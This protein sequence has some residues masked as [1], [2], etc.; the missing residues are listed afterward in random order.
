MILAFC[1]INLTIYS[2]E[3]KQ[4]SSEEIPVKVKDTTI[5]PLKDS[6]NLKLSDSLL[7][8][9]KDTIKK[10]VEL[11]EG[12]IEHSADS[13]IR[14]DIINNKI[15][16]YNN[17]HIHYKDI[18]LTAGYIEIDNNTNSVIAKG[19][20]DSVGTYSQLPVFKQGNQES[21]QDT[22]QFNFKSEKAKIWNLKTEQQGIIILGE[23]SKKHNDSIIFIENIRLTTSDKEKPDYYIKIPKAK[24]IKDKKLVAGSSQLV[25]AD[26]PTPIVLPF[27]YIPLTKGRTSG[28]LMPTWGENNRQGYFLQNGGYYFVLNDNFDL[29]VLGDIYTNGS[30]GLRTESGYA[31]RYKFS[32]NFNFR[33]ENLINSLKG[34]DD[35]S[36][37]T[38]YNIRWSHSQDAKA[39]PNSRFSASVNLGSSQ[40]Y[41]QSNNEYNTNAFLNNNLSSS[42]SYYKNFV[43]TPFNVSLSMTHSQNTN[44]EEIN[45][46]LPSLQLNMDRIYPFTGKNGVKKNAIQ[47]TGLTYTMKGDNR[48]VTNDEFFFKKEMFDEAKSGIQHNATMNTNMKALKYFTISPSLNY[49]EVWYFDRLS[50]KFDDIQNAVVTDTIS[51]FS[52]F[53]EYST[54]VSLGTTFYGMF[55]FKK[56]NI[57]AIRHVVRPSVSYSYRP[58]FSS[59]NEE[60]Q[61]SDDPNDIGEYS[62]FAN[63][64]F[65]KPGTG[66]SNSLNFTLNNNLEAKLRKKDSTDTETE[67]KKII[68]LNNLNFSSSYN[69]A[70]DSLKWSPVGVNAGTK[71]FNNKLNLNVRATLDPYALDVNGKKINTF[72]I[73][74]GGSLFRLTN[75]GLTMNYSLASKKDGKGK[76]KEE[77]N[78]EDNNSDGVFGENLTATNQQTPAGTG[79]KSETKESK[80][81]ES[82]IPW[83]LKLAYALNYANSNR[84]KEISSHSLMFSGDIELTPK[85]GVGFSSGYDMKNQGFSYTQLRFSRDLDSWKLNF[86]WVPFGDRQTYYF[87]IGVK[88]SML[89][90]L[91]YDKRQVPDKQLF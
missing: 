30:W 71:L 21:V 26:V 81:F 6:L 27:A 20:I 15:I 60:F 87:F 24:F 32:G 37:A 88:S 63:G 4:S 18:D 70:A 54:A 45:M 8:K 86:N 62:P 39:S 38:N 12:I 51:S 52:T 55:K 77:Q 58:D 16:L 68:L 89:S 64:I 67:A 75:A 13:L 49:K 48:I 90:D 42:I 25:I 79:N 50:K 1:F 29:A 56:G 83:T 11:L 40:Y 73:N 2:Q 85:W 53:R 47:K 3:I 69:M 17:A 19:I 57:E 5:I 34:F 80:L 78:E 43:G 72:N 61:Q 82:K 66:L 76:S 46:T 41:K 84:Q 14:Q 28:F 59:Y 7:I 23:V 65:G 31:K 35:Y 22:I 33:Y 74:N 91:K 10:P 9:P 44:T 36:K